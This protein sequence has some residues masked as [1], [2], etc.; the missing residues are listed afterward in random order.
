MGTDCPPS[1]DRVKYPLTCKGVNTANLQTTPE[2][3][4][5]MPA[6]LGD[7]LKSARRNRFV[8]RSGEIELFQ[9]A[10]NADEPP[11]QI[12]YVYGPGGI[13]KT[14]LLRE[15]AARAEQRSIAAYYLDGRN[16]EPTPDSFMR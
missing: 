11:F 8:G 3:N 2:R 12:M 13:G 9:S 16:L 10:L 4:E 14:T 5:H 7:R 15:F 1:C 6:R